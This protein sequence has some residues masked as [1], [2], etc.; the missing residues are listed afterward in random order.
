M[1]ENQWMKKELIDV[2]HELSEM[3][4]KLKDKEESKWMTGMYWF[5]FCV[6][7]FI[8]LFWIIQI[9]TIYRSEPLSSTTKIIQNMTFEWPTI[10]IWPYYSCFNKTALD[11]WKKEYGFIDTKLKNAKRIIPFE[12]PNR[13]FNWSVHN[14]SKMYLEGRYGP[15][16]YN[17]AKV[18][19]YRSSARNAEDCLQEPTLGKWDTYTTQYAVFQAF[20]PVPASSI[21]D[22]VKIRLNTSLCLHFTVALHPSTEKYYSFH[23]SA[24]R[25]DIHYQQYVTV[26]LQQEVFNRVSTRLA[27]CIADRSYS[28]A[29]CYDS[30]IMQYKLNKTGCHFPGITV[31]QQE[32]ELPECN[33]HSSFRDFHHWHHE[34][35]LH[36]IKYKDLQAEKAKC[37]EPCHTKIYIIADKSTRQDRKAKNK[38]TLLF[39]P[40]ARA[41]NYQ[42]VDESRA[43]TI[44]LMVANVGGILGLFLG[45]SCMTII[46]IIQFTITYFSKKAHEWGI[47]QKSTPIMSFN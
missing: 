27:P 8:A 47:R 13:N 39:Y 43:M 23:P 37:G 44:D 24:V 3:N 35:Y 18:C 41:M 19:I 15:P 4:K 20:S 22:F 29:H 36:E 45:I 31:Q 1:R 5:G 16:L 9:I 26:K 46:S 21:R 2:K 10:S 11:E 38:T 40:H 34:L 7:A 32:G 12:I 33:N 28:Q 6:F 30:T 25:F 42:Q 14:V 17:Y